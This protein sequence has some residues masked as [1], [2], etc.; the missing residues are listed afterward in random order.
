MVLS[1]PYRTAL[2]KFIYPLIQDST[3]DLSP[4]FHEHFNQW[5]STH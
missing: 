1:N 5:D 4:I 3:I 2:H